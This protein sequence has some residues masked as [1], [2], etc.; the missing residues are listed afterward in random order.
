[1]LRR[2]FRNALVLLGSEGVTRLLGFATTAILARRLGVETFGQL[3]FATAM[4]AYGVALSDF[5][6]VTTST[7]RMAEAGPHVVSTARSLLGVR[8]V[9][10]FVAAALLAT[11]TLFLPKPPIVRLLV[12]TYAAVTLVQSLTIEWLFV[13]LEKTGRVALSRLLTTVSYFGL[14]LFF[15]KGPA[16]LL[17]VPVSFA[18]ATALGAML[19]AIGAARD[20]SARILVPSMHDWRGILRSSW[21]VGLAGF[22]TMAHVNC[23][24]TF[25]ALM[26]SD[27]EAGLFAGASKLVFVFLAVDRVFYTVFL[28]VVARALQGTREN[29]AR[30]VGAAVR[31]A[32]AVGIPIFISVC[33]LAAP[34]LSAV[35]GGGYAGGALSLRVLSLFIPLTMV[36]SVFG[37]TVIA[38]SKERTFLLVSGIAALVSVASSLVLTTVLGG[39]GAAVALVCGEALMLV[40][41]AIACTRVVRIVLGLRVLSPLLAGAM[42]ALPLMLL[43]SSPLAGLLTGGL[44]YLGVLLATGGVRPA[45]LVRVGESR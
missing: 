35:M 2:P 5:G 33:V 16:N 23:G 18:T 12:A 4:L 42:M 37:Y 40:I 21:P 20:M 17:A 29:A 27:R 44:V 43:R 31:I 25:L 32:L 41:M 19:L 3:G 22:L 38:G 10:G 6:L 39:I 26:T 34:L 1:M 15:V 36:N 13:G 45:E 14:C 11:A 24:M 7:R 30:V 28:P 9:A 8:A